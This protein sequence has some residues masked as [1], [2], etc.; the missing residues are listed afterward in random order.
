MAK[1][2][3]MAEVQRAGFNI[4]T[5]QRNETKFLRTETNGSNS[6]LIYYS[7]LPGIDIIYNNL[8]SAY[9]TEVQYQ[10]GDHNVIELNYCLQGIFQ[11][12]LSGQLFS[13]NEGELE[14]HLWGIAKEEAH[15]PTKAYKG[16]TLLI[17]PDKVVEYMS[18]V[19]PEF[20]IHM[21]N[22]QDALERYGNVVR[23]KSTP[24]IVTTFQELYKLNPALQHY[25]LKLK[26]LEVLGLIQT[27]PAFAHEARVY[28]S[29][30]DIDKVKAIHKKIVA[31]LERHYSLAELA[32]E[33]KIGK[34]TLQKCFQELY[35]KPYYAFLKHYRMRRALTYLEEGQLSIV[36]IAGKLGYGNPSKFAAAFRSVHGV[37]PRDYKKINL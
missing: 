9:G 22:L 17:H 12:R 35:G 13:L 4:D 32:E 18:E 8:R 2:R 16:I 1:K 19:F 30:K 3:F 25:L 5:E 20:D 23:I 24:E 11:C 6:S 21:A 15:F 27:M 37:A 36:E 14:A 31:E 10:T 26:V 34:T 7:V 33:Y 29:L 28:H